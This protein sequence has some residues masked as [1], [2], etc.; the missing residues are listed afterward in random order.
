[1]ITDPPQIRSLINHMI[2]G[3]VPITVMLPE[4]EGFFSSL[5]LDS[6]RED[7]SLLADELFPARGH[8][9][10]EPGMEIRVLGNL[11]GIEVRFR[12]RVIKIHAAPPAASYSLAMPT[13]MDYKQR[14]NA[15]RVPVSPASAI[16]VHLRAEG[17]NAKGTLTDIS[18]NG[19]RVAMRN[20]SS[21]PMGTELLC[22][23]E[24]P[25]EPISAKAE[26]RHSEPDR[27]GLGVVYV[28]FRF[29]ELNREH[30]RTINR[31]TANLQRDQL[32][33]RR[34]FHS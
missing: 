19:L 11:D 2:R 6:D 20:A 7:G 29:L 27:R 28:G 22:E 13:A 18:H 30:Q 12:S 17:F 14:R 4:R 5:L 21:L 31:F 3:K 15:F 26:A 24:L 9:A 10:V 23:I 1:M 32:R 33:A 8:Q 16:P 25:N 34:M